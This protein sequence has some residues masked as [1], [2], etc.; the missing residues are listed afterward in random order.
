[1]SKFKEQDVVSAI[2]AQVEKSKKPQNSNKKY[3]PENYFSIFLPEGVNEE[4]FQ[5]RVLPN[6][7]K[8]NPSPFTEVSTHKFQMPDGKWKTF[9]CPKEHR[10]A[11]CPFCQARTKLLATGNS[12]DKKDAKNYN[13][14]KMYIIKLI[15]RNK[16][17]EGVKFWRFNANYDGQGIFDKIVAIVKRKKT[18]IT[19]PE[20]GRDI[21]VEV[22][23]SQKGYP[24]VSS[25][26]DDDSSVLSDNASQS[27]EWLSDERTWEDVY[28]VKPY[29]Y[30]RLVVEGEDPYFDK[31]SGT[32]ITK[33]SFE[34]KKEQKAN[35]LSST[36]EI[37]MGG[38]SIT[39]NGIKTDVPLNVVKPP[40]T[41]VEEEDDLPF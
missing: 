38:G 18:D 9:M 16:E 35:E 30:L 23:R 39:E 34:L 25:I 26:L 8:N 32:F 12:Q 10:D 40:S 6:T 29:D 7:D 22:K 33:E 17:N 27:N 11:D 2:L 15:S 24:V 4:T 36:G 41:N 20:T 21:F 1:M 13:T 5:I 14:K 3:N 37:S 19:N 28:S 31:E